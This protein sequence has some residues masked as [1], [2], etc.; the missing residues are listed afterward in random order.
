MWGA[1]RKRTRRLK[2]H[3]T[4]SINEAVVGTLAETSYSS[5]KKKYFG[6]LEDGTQMYGG[7]MLALMHAVSGN[8]MIK[9]HAKKKASLEAF[10]IT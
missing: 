6:G 4:V 7:S 5:C 9:S 8:R 10:N 1:L 3:E 2:K